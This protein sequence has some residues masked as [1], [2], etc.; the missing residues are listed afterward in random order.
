M[1][2][3]FVQDFSP[4]KVHLY[5]IKRMY[6]PF[7]H[8]LNAN[9]C[10]YLCSDIQL[11]DCTKE[12]HT[13]FECVENN[14]FFQSLPIYIRILLFLTIFVQVYSV[15]VCGE[16]YLGYQVKPLLN[17]GNQIKIF[18]IDCFLTFV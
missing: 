8:I 6:K 15:C 5:I 9:Y 18:L 1:Y 17:A 11:M 7:W 4:E 14:H 10:D 2:H 12:V 16:N 13:F 3:S